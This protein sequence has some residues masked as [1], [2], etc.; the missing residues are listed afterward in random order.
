MLESLYTWLE[1][2]AVLLARASPFLLLG[3]FG[4]GL[5]KALLPPD[6]TVRLLGQGRLRSITLAA[7]IGAPL[8]L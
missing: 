3:L 5:L 6:L 4:A 7:F 8:P 1:A 2:A